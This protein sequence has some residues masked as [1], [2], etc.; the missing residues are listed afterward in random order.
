MRSTASLLCSAALLVGAALLPAAAGATSQG[1]RLDGP[2]VGTLPCADCEGIVTALAILRDPR[3]A[4]IGYRL[5]QTY[6]TTRPGERVFNRAGR[7]WAFTH[8]GGNPAASGLRL[9]GG[10]DNAP[11]L[12]VQLSPT[13]VEL[14]G[15]DGKRIDSAL[16][17]RLVLDPKAALPEP[18]A[19]RSL[20]AGTL[21]RQPGGTGWQFQPCGGRAARVAIDVSPEN[22]LTAVLTD[23]GFDRRDS[24]YVE[25][26]GRV[27]RGGGGRLL[28]EALNRAGFEMGCA[29]A[30]GSK[31]LRIV[32]HGNEPG[33]TLRSSGESTLL[34]E[35]GVT[36]SAP[37]VAPTWHWGG[38]AQRV[39]ARL[40]VETE[41][42]ALRAT[43]TPG[44][45]RDTMADAA[46]GYRARVEQTRPTARTLDGCGYLGADAR[47]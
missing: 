26:F 43:L 6:L 9:D 32:A 1:P 8:A 7:A 45:C 40:S 42:I 22:M 17:Y 27:E 24:L 47:P 23:L 12:L 2:Y 25:A 29:A 4:P 11:L 33:W 37:A 30:G 34:I 28:F 46:F 14:L 5:R 13:V 10:A 15:R 20:F 35:P 3:G 36:R 18:P 19:P 31:A 41:S 21:R 38:N 44:I 39:G 16:D